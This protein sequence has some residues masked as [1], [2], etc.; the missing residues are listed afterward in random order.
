MSSHDS[1]GRPEPS[2]PPHPT[3]SPG[4][5]AAPDPTAL[6]DPLP[7]PHPALAALGQ[8]RLDQPLGHVLQEVCDLAAQVLVDVDALSVTLVDE[9][10]SARSAAF[11]GGLAAL[12]DE[13]QYEDGFGPCMDAARSGGVVRIRDTSTDPT[14]PG[15][16]A[17]AQR[18]GV[19]SVVSVGVPW[20]DRVVGALNLF[21]CGG[22]A[23]D[24]ES[25]E[26]AGV[27][28]G[29]AGAA[30]AHAALLTSTAERAGQMQEAMRS[31]AVIEQAKGVLAAALGLEPEEAFAE[32]S[33]RSQRS[34]T[35]LRDVA[36]QVVAQALGA[37]ADADGGD[38]A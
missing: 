7:P 33:R 6:G 32:L 16:S 27:F 28:A 9:A 18:H 34:N 23:L 11:A 14:Y 19:T 1:S 22:V 31:R 26:V 21:S 20:A 2:A 36:A 35:K 3:A 8:I 25:V 15:F 13:R 37:H 29:Y 10:G 5:T 38:R 30:L 12:L 24:D 17:L 4:P